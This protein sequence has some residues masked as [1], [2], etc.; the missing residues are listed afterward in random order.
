MPQLFMIPTPQIWGR[1]LFLCCLCSWNVV[2]TDVIIFWG[3]LPD[4]ILVSAGG[5][6]SQDEAEEEA[7]AIT[8]KRTKKNLHTNKTQD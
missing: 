6:S 3:L 7:K 8:V 4:Q 1:A 2:I 5:D